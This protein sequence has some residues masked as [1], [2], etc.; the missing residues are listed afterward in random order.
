MQAPRTIARIV[1]LK[2]DGAAQ[3]ID[4]LRAKGS[5]LIQSAGSPSFFSLSSSADRQLRLKE[6]PAAPGL[7]IS[8]LQTWPSFA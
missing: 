1:S 6:L 4:L 8:S 7:A 5:R 2:C 3:K